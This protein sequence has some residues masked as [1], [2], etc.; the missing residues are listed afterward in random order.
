MLTI[1]KCKELTFFLSFSFFFFFFFFLGGG[2]ISNFVLYYFGLSLNIANFTMQRPESKKS[3]L[4][5]QEQFG[6]QNNI[7]KVRLDMCSLC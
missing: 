4:Q 6:N 2:G 1:D 3:K 5:I 7:L